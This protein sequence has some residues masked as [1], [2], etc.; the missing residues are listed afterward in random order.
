MLT[1]LDA[2]IKVKIEAVP[3]EKRV[4]VT[5]HDAFGYWGRRYGFEIHGIQGTS[6]VSEASAKDIQDL[7][8][9]ISDRKIRSIFV[10]S[11][12]PTATIDALKAAVESRGWKVTIGGSL[13][14]DAMGDIGTPE[15]TYYGMMMHNVDVIVN[16]LK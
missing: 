11:S 8:K 1:D 6:T 13:F 2:E 12:V 15:G 4:L 9:L 10:E 7:A 16:S 5:G 3:Q 14:S